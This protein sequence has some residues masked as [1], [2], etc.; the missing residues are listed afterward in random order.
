MIRAT[1][2]AFLLLFAAGSSLTKCKDGYTGKSNEKEKSKTMSNTDNKNLEAATLGAGCFWCVEAIFS[3]L[4]GVESVIPGY[5]GGDVSDP[6]YKTV[7]TGTTGHAE[8]CRIYFDPA[9]ISYE[10]I[11]EVFWTTH[12]P[13][14]LNRQGND[15]GTQYRSVIFY[16]DENQKRIAEKSKKEVATK[17]WDRPVV[18]EI[19]PL[20]N[21]Y[22]A[23]N[24]HRNYFANNPN[25][26]YCRF[27]IEPKVL[28]FRKMFKDKLKHK[29]S[30]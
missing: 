14:T 16:H 28:K 2:Y 15:I 13:T 11:L 29:T 23:E 26:A 5:S 1:I 20:K 22:P 25:Q 9:K 17:I 24:Y 8:V 18:T 19:S 7:C 6:D 3:E 27:V 10:E 4:E 30:E 12:D 21:F